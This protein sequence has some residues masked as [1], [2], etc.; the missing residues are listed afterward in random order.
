M[1][2]F[3]PTV[4]PDRSAGFADP[5][6]R[7]TGEVIV[8]D[9]DTNDV[10]VY[11]KDG[12]PVATIT[13]FDEP[14]GM[15]AD[16]AGNLYIADTRSSEILVY[17]N[18]YKTKLRT[19]TDAN[20]FPS[21]VSYDPTT[22]A[23]AVTNISK[24]GGVAPGSVS[25][26]AK[27]ASTPCVTVGNPFFTAVYFGAYD[28]HGNFYVDGLGPDKN[29]VVGVVA[30]GCKATTITQLTTGNTIYFPGGVQVSAAGDVLIDDQSRTKIYTYRPPYNRSLGMPI[31][32][33]PLTVASDPVTFALTHSD[34]AVWTANA[35]YGSASRI[36]YPGG[37][38]NFGIKGF[39]YPIGIVV[40]PV[41][42]P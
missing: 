39:K 27:N 17:A 3:A 10:Y 40:T 34:R 28:S 37:N 2:G 12:K 9:D 15:A 41:A 24:T 42:E 21:D 32:T 8:A 25:L 29:V 33:T 1:P 20:E 22:G 19:L 13:G 38:A 35:A 31:A 11:A 36:S 26:Y 7:I 30:G 5:D 6:A 16:P 4:T 18:D 23:I 14:Q